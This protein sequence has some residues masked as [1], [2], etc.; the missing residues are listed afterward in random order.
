LGSYTATQHL[1]KLGHKRIAFFAG[2]QAAPWT[3]ERFEGYRRALREAG[4]D[5]NDKLIFQSGRTMEDG[6]KAALQMINESGDATAVQAVNDIVAIGCAQTLLS[7]G[8]RIPEDISV[9]GFGNILLSEHFRIPL[10]TIRQPKFRLG[11]AAM[12]VML[13]LLRGHPGESKRLSAELIARASSG[14]APAIG[15]LRQLSA[16]NKETL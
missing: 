9:V 3:Q 2:P 14:I 1:L 11:I 7:Q 5:V 10:T 16:P 6:A 15:H 8:V 13:Q 12:D 4:Q